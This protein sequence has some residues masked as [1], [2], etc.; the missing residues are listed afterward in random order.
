MDIIDIKYPELSELEKDALRQKQRRVDMQSAFSQE[1]DPLFFKAMRTEIDIQVWLDK[2]KEI[3]D[4]Y[5]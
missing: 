4:R 1:S 5:K 3:R 2:V